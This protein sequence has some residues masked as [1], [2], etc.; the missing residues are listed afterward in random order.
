MARGKIVVAMSGGVDSSTTAFLLKQ[1]GYEVVG[2]HFQ[3]WQ[4]PLEWE[5]ATTPRKD[6]LHRHSPHDA[7]KV[8]ELLGIQLFTVDIAERFRKK[9]VDP[10][11]KEYLA[12]RTPNP[13]VVC[14]EEIKLTLLLQKAKD[15]G[16][17]KVAT[18]HYAVVEFDTA[19]GRYILRR[20][21]DRKK[22]QSYYLGRLTREKLRFLKTPLG[23]M[24]KA[25]VRRI[26][27]S[28]GLPVAGK[29]ESQELCFIPEQDYRRFVS[30]YA[31]H[32]LGK[33][34][35]TPGDILDTRGNV[36]G[37]H[38]GIPFY[39]IGQRKGLGISSL[40]PLYVVEIDLSRNVIIVGDKEEV[41]ARGLIGERANWVS[42]DPPAT[43][44]E[45]DCQIRYRHPPVKARV[46]SFPGDKVKVIFSA[47][48][49]AI[50]PGQLAVFYHQDILLGS[51]FI[52]GV[53]R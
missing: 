12:G 10:F 32:I 21:V 1:E 5:K 37:K 33:D 18:G 30:Q 44:I 39:T 3:V 26:A 2:V 49:P 53:L 14:N 13:C 50:T 29:T 19:Q 34:I 28:A 23:S 27:E 31:Q 36:I 42:I 4:P 47:E 11:V 22:E 16:A 6:H 9:I 46:E 51:A 43:E 8:A 35:N 48:Q 41:M 7:L 24:T 52:T 45:V 25:E 17:E 15:V 40:R 20:G 38:K